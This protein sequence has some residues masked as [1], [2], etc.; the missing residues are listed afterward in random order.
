MDEFSDFMLDTIMVEP[1]LLTDSYGTP[2]FGAAVSY[3]CRISG[4]QRQ[5]VDLLG[6]ERISTA[7]IDLMGTPPINPTDRVTLPSTFA[8]SQPPIL[9]VAVYSD[10]NGPH[11]LQ[12]MV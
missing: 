8:P 12:L 7:T 2:T 1:L 10:Q 4:R 5:V 6:R 11:H 9:S 3:P